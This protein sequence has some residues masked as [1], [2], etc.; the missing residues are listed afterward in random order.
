MIIFWSGFIVNMFFMLTINKDNFNQEIL[1]HK[2]VVFVDFYA[3]WCGP[4][5][6]TGPIIEEIAKETPNIKFVKVNVDENTELASQYSVFSIPTFIIF[7]N[8][9]PAH[10]FVGAMSK[11]TFLEEI[12][13]TE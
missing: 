5:K 6:T 2:G 13:K 12:K 3:E 7:K 8:G 11:E 4:C 9:Q 1:D 10:Q